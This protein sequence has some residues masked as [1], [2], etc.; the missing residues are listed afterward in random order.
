MS[1]VTVSVTRCDAESRICTF[2]LELIH[3]LPSYLC[4]RALGCVLN[5]LRLMLR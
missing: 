3:Y 4:T 2:V 1:N 5:C